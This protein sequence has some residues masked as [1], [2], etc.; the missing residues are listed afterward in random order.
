MIP[1]RAFSDVGLIG[2]NFT[3]SCKKRKF[4]NVFESYHSFSENLL[5]LERI[6]SENAIISI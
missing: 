4:E 5:G 2:K 3:D 6:M 1:N